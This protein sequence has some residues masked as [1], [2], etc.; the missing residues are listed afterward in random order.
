VE[1]RTGGQ[2]E[3]A[4]DADG[5]FQIHHG[6]RPGGFWLAADPPSALKPPDPDPETGAE[7]AWARTYYPGVTTR[8]AGAR[9]VAGAGA[10]LPNLDWKLQ[11][12][13]VHSVRGVLLGPDG[14]PAAGVAITAG[15]PGDPSSRA[16]SGADGTFE[17]RLVDGEWPLSAKLET[18]AATLRARQW[19]TVAG[20]DLDRLQVR[21]AAPLTVR[22]IVSIE[23]PEA[24]PRPMKLPSVAFRP[25]ISPLFG[26]LEDMPVGA[27]DADGSFRAEVY[28]GLYR[29]L[30]G[31]APPGYYLDATRLGDVPLTAAEVELSGDAVVTV[32]Y[33]S[34][35]ATLRGTAENCLT[36]QVVV[37]PV[38]RGLRMPAT[39]GKGWCDANN[40]F[41]ISSMRPG[42]YYALAVAGSADIPPGGLPNYDEDTLRQAVRVTLRAGEITETNLHAIY[43]VQ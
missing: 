35:G 27:P 25:H 24:V 14:N 26:E 7:R 37:I 36:G 10:V 33:R 43:P 13:P 42:E 8:E 41:Q 30:G 17:L 20:R 2:S 38:D 32:V 34:N 19:V 39:F 28:P 9:I 22:G 29:I 15:D 1:Y 6:M 23:A 31:A 18:A 12:V 40:R 16:W 21:L 3:K 11:A 4:T 5:R